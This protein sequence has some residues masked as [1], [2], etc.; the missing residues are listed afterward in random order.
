VQRHV[1]G[2]VV[3]L[4]RGGEA[5]AERIAGGFLR[6]KGRGARA[7]RRIMVHTGIAVRTGITEPERLAQ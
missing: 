6:A 1:T 3:T 4:L 5:G 2:P 7:A